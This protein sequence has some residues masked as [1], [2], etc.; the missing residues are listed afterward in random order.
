MEYDGTR[1]DPLKVFTTVDPEED[2][3]FLCTILGDACSPKASLNRDHGTL[4]ACIGGQKIIE[5]FSETEGSGPK[6]NSE[7][8]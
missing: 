8:S 2:R 1:N 6:K 4:H 7:W 5:L 3:Y